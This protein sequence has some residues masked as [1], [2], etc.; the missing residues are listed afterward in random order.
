MV[1]GTSDE[2]CRAGSNRGH[3]I[4]GALRKHIANE[5]FFASREPPRGPAPVPEAV[6]YAGRLRPP[7]ETPVAIRAA[8]TPMRY[9]LS[10]F[11]IGWAGILFQARLLQQIILSLF[12]PLA[13]FL[14]LITGFLQQVV[15]GAPVFEE[16][17]KFGPPL[18][19]A[20]LFGIR[21]LW[22]RM[23]LAWA[24]GAAFGVMEHYVTYAEEPLELFVGRIVFHAA[25]P[26][27]SMLVYTALES[28]PDAR[29][30]WAS[31]IPSTLVHW[32]N[33]F[34]AVVL[35]SASGFLPIGE[36][37]VLAWATLM[38]AAIVVLTVVGLFW[39]DRFES[40]LRRTIET[41]MPRLGFAPARGSLPEERAFDDF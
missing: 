27:V 29:A 5:V 33:N 13:A 6:F 2:G 20:S 26:G 19:V 11:L 15:F 31:T 24:S 3:A 41:A 40:T 28:M 36:P 18:L 12:Q 35:A 30:R 17:A 25:A 4:R 1:C 7:P 38:T 21:T 16:L 39:R 32:G 10:A 22:I 37:V 34:G 9:A 8:A 14:E 23:P